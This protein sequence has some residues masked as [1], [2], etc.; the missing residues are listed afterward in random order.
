[1]PRAHCCRRTDPPRRRLPVGSSLG[2]RRSCCPATGRSLL[3]AVEQFELQVSEGRAWTPSAPG[4]WSSTTTS[5][6]RARASARAP[7]HPSASCDKAREPPRHTSEGVCCRLS[8]S[9][10]EG[11]TPVQGA[12]PTPGRDLRGSASVARRPGASPTGV[13]WYCS[14][15]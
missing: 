15:R 11:P 14:A 9:A 4:H 10:C 13:P 5:T 12:N 6:R 7:A 8:L 2:T 1:L 3:V